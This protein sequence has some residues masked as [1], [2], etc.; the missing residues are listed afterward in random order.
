MRTIGPPGSSRPAPERRSRRAAGGARSS[1]TWSAWSPGWMRGD[2]SVGGRR[3]GGRRRWTAPSS[4]YCPR[5]PVR[6]SPDRERARA[7]R[8]SS[9]MPGSSSRSRRSTPRL[10]PPGALTD[11][12]SGGRRPLRP[13]FPSPAA[14]HA[15]GTGTMGPPGSGPRCPGSNPAAGGRWWRG[16]G[17]TP[18]RVAL[19]QAPRRSSPGAAGPRAGAVAVEPWCGWPS[20]RRR[21]GR[22]LVRLA[23]GQAPRRSSPGAAGPRAGA[24][25]YRAA[26]R[27]AWGRRAG[28]RAP[29]MKAVSQAARTSSAGAPARRPPAASLGSRGPHGVVLATPLTAVLMVLVKRIYVEGLDWI[30]APRRRRRWTACRTRRRSGPGRRSTGSSLPSR[31]R[32][33]R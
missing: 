14:Q 28:R 7:S 33:C 31:R 27:R 13:M 3:G 24:A 18:V 29:G 25:E 11:S 2:S 6:R 9:A 19:G 26:Q 21:G 17:R 23:L 15:H 5:L 12:H 20:G 30:R 16:R 8:R 32:P 22:A 4:H 10:S 1:S